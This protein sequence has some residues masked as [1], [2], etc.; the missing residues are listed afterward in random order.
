MFCVLLLFVSVF[1]SAENV[2]HTV[3]KGDTVY[4]LARQYNVKEADIL[5][6]NGIADVRKIYVGQKLR[7]PS[8]AAAASP[9]GRVALE[10]RAVQGDTL[11]G[12]ARKYGISFQELAAANNFPANYI[13]KVGNT[14]KV[15]FQAASNQAVPQE[16]QYAEPARQPAKNADFQPTSPPTKAPTQNAKPAPSGAPAKTGKPLGSLE[17]P[18]VPKSSAYMKGKLSGVVLTGEKT[19][20]VR[21]LTAGIVISAGPYRGFGRVVIIKSEGGFDYVYGG[22]ESLSVKKWDRVVPGSEV[23]KL[24]VDTLSAKPQL[25]FMIYHN[26]KPIDPA[27]TPHV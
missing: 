4:S 9:V 10:Y 19:E 27:K 18:V 23:G 22:C 7:I 26:G 6:I 13:L 8:L 17:W 25:F 5:A 21:S 20:P 2:Y 14:I 12:I 24:G 11:Y 16:P 15:P 1:L 3:R